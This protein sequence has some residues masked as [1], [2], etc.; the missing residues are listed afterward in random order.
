MHSELSQKLAQ[1]ALGYEYMGT[2]NVVDVHVRHLRSKID[3]RLGTPFVR[4]V[5]GVGYVVRGDA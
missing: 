5:R 2:S 3:D 1:L 4:T